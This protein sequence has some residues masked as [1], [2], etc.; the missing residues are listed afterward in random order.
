MCLGS[1]GSTTSRPLT[2]RSSKGGFRNRRRIYSPHQQHRRYS[3]A[4]YTMSMDFK[5]AGSSGMGFFVQGGYVGRLSRRSLINKDLAM[6]D[7]S[8]GSEVRPIV[9]PGGADHPETESEQGPNAQIGA[10][11][12]WKTFSGSRKQHP[13]RDSARGIACM[14]P[15]ARIARAR[16]REST[17]SAIPRAAFTAVR[18]VPVAVLGP[19][20]LELGWQGYVPLDAV[21]GPQA[22]QR[23][24]MFDFNFTYGKCSIWHL[25]RRVEDPFRA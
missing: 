14:A 2:C 21:A 15:A 23:R 18:H 25:H 13:D 22:V 12:F 4:P 24:L 3:Q 1:P 17:S 19:F 7:Q 9:F 8:G 20:G 10:Q 16:Y 5:F 6:P 11:P